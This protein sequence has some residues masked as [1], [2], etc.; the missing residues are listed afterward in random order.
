MIYYDH[1]QALDQYW[2]EANGCH[3]YK[4]GISFKVSDGTRI[5]NDFVTFYDGH[6]TDLW[7]YK[8]YHSI[9]VLFIVYVHDMDWQVLCKL[10]GLKT[11]KLA[12][13]VITN[14]RFIDA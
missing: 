3:Q 11:D 9:G 7:H 10:H 6:D 4:Y 13:G 14:P 12:S 1:S 2:Q 5:L 8:Q